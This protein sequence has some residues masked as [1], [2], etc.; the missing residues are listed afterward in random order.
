MLSRSNASIQ[1]QE[2]LPVEAPVEPAV[3][4][5]PLALDPVGVLAGIEAMPPLALLLPLL[6]PLLVPLLLLPVPEPDAG[7]GAGE[8]AWEGAGEE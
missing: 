4:F 1:V 8:G 5:M 7:E 2:T 6:V 3:P